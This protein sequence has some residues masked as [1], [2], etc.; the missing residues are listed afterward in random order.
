MAAQARTDTAPSIHPASAEAAG[1]QTD[2]QMAPL[3][4]SAPGADQKSPQ[5]LGCAQ[6]GHGA[7]LCAARPRCE[8]F[9]LVLNEFFPLPGPP[10]CLNQDSWR[11][12]AH[13]AGLRGAERCSPC[14]GHT[15]IAGFPARSLTIRLV[16]PAAGDTSPL[17]HS[18]ALLFSTIPPPR[19]GESW[20][21]LQP[22]PGSA[23]P[24][25]SGRC[26]LWRSTERTN[27]PCSGL[28]QNETGAVFLLNQTAG[29][30][31]QEGVCSIVV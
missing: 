1:R 18:V 16:P 27:Q 19:Y 5:R 22:A 4:T 28:L 25:G 15:V 20:R 21:T 13:P 14:A 17:R 29:L 24:P 6:P 10:E 30:L 8:W 11:G 7:G 12:A 3:R 9:V 31:H 23:L 26:Q 2:R